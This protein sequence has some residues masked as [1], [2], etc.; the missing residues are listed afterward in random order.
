[1]A[2]AQLL[3]TM[4]A[5]ALT[6]GGTFAAAY[7]I[8]KERAIFKREK[9]INLKAS[10]YVLSKLLILGLFSLFQVAVFLL[11]MA[12]VVDFGFKGAVFGLGIF[13]LFVTFYLAVLA[14]IAFG[15]LI[16]S[17]IPSQDVVLYAILAQLF[18]QIVLTGTL[19]PL[20]NSVASMLSPGYWA[21]VSA[22]STIDLPYLNEHSRVCSVN[23]IPN[24]QTGAKELRAMCTDAEQ[25]LAIPYEHSEKFVIYTWLGMISHIFLWS[26]LTII[27]QAR[28]KG[29]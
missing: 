11:M 5:L 4:M 25:D 18:V 29:E 12:L 26:V 15:L 8:V 3:V 23:E 24:P 27:V 6:Q 1:L 2:D 9:A 10:A 22:G 19:F 13:E 28:K 20:D 16:S 7:E 21:T 14:S 17:V